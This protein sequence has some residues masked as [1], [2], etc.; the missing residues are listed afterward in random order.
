MV[1][2]F[3]IVDGRLVDLAL[4]FWEEPDHRLVTGYR[5]LEDIVRERTGLQEHGFAVG[6]LTQYLGPQG[7]RYIPMASRNSATPSH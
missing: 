6:P 4:S 7:L 3:A 2:P 5:R 1:V